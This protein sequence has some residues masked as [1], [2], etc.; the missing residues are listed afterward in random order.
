M[1]L[2]DGS[3]VDPFRVK[4][5]LKAKKQKKSQGSSHYKPK[6]PTELTQLTCLKG[7]SFALFIF[8]AILGFHS[9]LCSFAF[10]SF[11]STVKLTNARLPP[12]FVLCLRMSLI[13]SFIIHVNIYYFNLDTTCNLILF[14]YNIHNIFKV[15]QKL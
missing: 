2:K 7:K 12:D 8:L 14:I 5:E 11:P 4:N 3:K 13:H 15:H 10:C 1:S 6:A 9:F